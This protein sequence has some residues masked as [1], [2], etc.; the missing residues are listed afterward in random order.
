MVLFKLRIVNG[1]SGRKTTVLKASIRVL[2]DCGGDHNINDT[3]LLANV[4]KTFVDF[5]SAF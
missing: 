5:R 2:G 4:V 3:E 1:N